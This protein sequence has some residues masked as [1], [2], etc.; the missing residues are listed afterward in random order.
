MS[1]TNPC[2]NRTTTTAMEIASAALEQHKA[3]ETSGDNNAD[4]DRKE[5]DPTA[6][7]DAE[8]VPQASKIRT[9]EHIQ[10]AVLCYS[11][12]LAGA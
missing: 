3:H 2:N 8:D 6:V 4:E 12:F 5:Q 11:L 1:G 9:K 10:F 7:G